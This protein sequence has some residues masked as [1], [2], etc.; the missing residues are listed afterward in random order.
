MANGASAT[1]LLLHLHLLARLLRGSQRCDGCLRAHAPY[2]QHQRSI[3]SQGMWRWRQWRLKSA[4][5]CVCGFNIFR[6]IPVSSVHSVHSVHSLGG[7]SVHEYTC[8]WFS[9][10][11]FDPHDRRIQLPYLPYPSQP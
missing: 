7:H 4:F 2:P 11:I 6:V 5:L 1:C 3:D 8:A 9:S 10:E